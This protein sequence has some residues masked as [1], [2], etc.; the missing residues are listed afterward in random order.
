[1]S[2]SSPQSNFND[3]HRNAAKFVVLL[4]PEDGTAPTLENEV[5]FLNL[6]SFACTAGGSRLDAGKVEYRLDITR[7]RI[8]DIASPVQF[9]R[10]IEIRRLDEDG[11]PTIVATWGFLQQPNITITDKTESL[12]IDFRLDPF[13]F[14]N[15][16][17]ET[18]IWHWHGGEEGDERELRTTHWPYVFN[19][20]I[21]DKIEGNRTTQQEDED[22]DDGEGPYVFANPEAYRTNTARG[23]GQGD[24]TREKWK[25]SE[26]VHRLCWSCNPDETYITNPKLDELEDVFGYYQTFNELQNH[27]CEF[28]KYLP[29]QLDA[30]LRPH[31]FGWFLQ[32]SLNDDDE[33]ETKLAFYRRGEGVP[34]QLLIQRVGKTL[35]M[36]KTNVES[37]QHSVNLVELANEVTVRGNFP[38]YES[39]FPLGPGWDIGYDTIDGDGETLRGIETLDLNHEFGKDHRLVGRQYVLN[40]AG[41]FCDPTRTDTNPYDFEEDLPGEWAIVRRRFHPCISR[42]ADGNDEEKRSY[43]YV[44]E[45]WDRDVEGADDPDTTDDPGWKRVKEGYSVLEHQCGILFT[46]PPGRLWQLVLEYTAPPS[47][48]T[49]Y[50][51][52]LRIT[53][54]VYADKQM[55]STAEKR[56]SSPQ[57]ETIELLMDMRD[58]FHKREVLPTSVLY[59]KPDPDNIDDQDDLD[60]YAEKVRDLEDAGEVSC[61]FTLFGV[62]HAEYAIGDVIDKV[63]GRNIELTA[64]NP[65]STTPRRLQVVGFNF[66][67]GNEQ[68]TELLV[69]TFKAE[70]PQL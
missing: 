54:S 16:L 4:G 68:K 13:V 38:R 33:R 28:G 20:K 7:Q 3:Q 65:D 14:G 51:L 1:M 5:R 43:G 67:V 31:G 58:K 12:T 21:D 29:D 70:R 69:E 59:E 23:D 44:V 19:P 40:E 32:H 47:G 22:F 63:D 30:L 15:P 25:L 17:K 27:S 50:G 57:A 53:A 39:T 24:D 55:E 34:R 35:K 10:Q 61:S 8:M 11:E 49:H 36:S 9:H 52:N 45:W 60:T 41:D 37:F 64:N 62:D 18:P 42:T 48:V 6:L 26:A 66:S 46:Q 56:D 2:I